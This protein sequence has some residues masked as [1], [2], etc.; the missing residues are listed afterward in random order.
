M[1]GFVGIALILAW[2]IFEGIDRETSPDR[3]PDLAGIS[4]KAS[5]SSLIAAIEAE[6]AKR[7]EP[8][9]WDQVSR[10]SQAVLART[11]LSERALAL[12]GLSL[13]AHGQPEAAKAAMTQAASQNLSY[14]LPHL[15]L[16]NRLL[17]EGDVAGALSQAD[18]VLRSQ[19]L[20]SD[21]FFPSFRDLLE[22]PTAADALVSAL[23]ENPP[24]RTPFLVWMAKDPTSTAKATALVAE[25][26][27]GDAPPK[28][29]EL[30]PL[31]NSL[32]AAGDYQQALFLWLRGLPNDRFAT[33]DYLTN[34][35]FRFPITKLPFDWSLSPVKGAEVS[36][37]STSG[38]ENALRVQFY[39]GRVPF[40]NVAKLLV[41]PPGNY[42]L[43]GRER[44]DNLETERGMVWKLTCAIPAAPLLA[45]T[46]PLKGNVSWQTFEV[47]F[48]VPSTD[49][50]A[51]WLRLE[52]D[53]R[54]ALEQEVGGGSVWYDDLSITRLDQKATN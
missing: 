51:Q 2:A 15:W 35:D 38:A 39:R 22:S 26:Q 30:A 3:S 48:E 27:Q 18:V 33:M 25:L 20:F 41:L 11:P 36:I 40:R 14:A 49:C 44:A 47:P 8:T 52:L 53:A 23:E 46:E 16:Y 54:V 17:T 32:I 42:Q 28:N 10:A 43:S 37:A 6:A 5:P 34:G 12:Y 19:S 1:A 50:P 4:L 31:L 24:W 9:D 45:Q 29:D 21:N 7:D 13:E